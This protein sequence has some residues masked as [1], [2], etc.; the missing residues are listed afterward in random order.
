MSSVELGLSEGGNVETPPSSL[1]SLS[2]L[3]SLSSG[4]DSY[5]LVG[6]GEGEGEGASINS[7]NDSLLPTRFIDSLTK[8]IPW[9]RV[10]KDGR[11]YLFGEDFL[12]YLSLEM[13]FRLLLESKMAW[14]GAGHCRK[15]MPRVATV[16]ET[17]YG[18]G[19]TLWEASD[20][21]SDLLKKR[22]SSP[23][24]ISQQ[25][26]ELEDDSNSDQLLRD[27]VLQ[28]WL[29]HYRKFLDKQAKK[30]GRVAVNLA[31]IP[32][33]A[34]PLE[35]KKSVEDLLAWEGAVVAIDPWWQDDRWNHDGTV[36]V[37]MPKVAAADLVTKASEGLLS[38][39]P[40]VRGR[41][42]SNASTVSSTSPRRIKAWLTRSNARASFNSSRSNDSFVSG[43]R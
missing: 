43:K 4:G 26:L 29:G 17:S 30:V 37:Y 35:I 21:V 34:G 24:N 41:V 12:P 25:S 6:V 36:T 11:S 1:S 7:F 5:P 14:G 15:L 38:I 28:Q 16:L 23:T 39:S 40:V 9:E 42:R 8:Q 2:S 27:V 3:N 13:K 22:S 31:N 32:Y 10:P 18:Y 33:T 20:D 19:I